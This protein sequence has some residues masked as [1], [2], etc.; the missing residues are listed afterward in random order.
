MEQSL[1]K[2]PIKKYIFLLVKNKFS[3]QPPTESSDL[4]RT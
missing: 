4:G 2:I 3:T 1:K